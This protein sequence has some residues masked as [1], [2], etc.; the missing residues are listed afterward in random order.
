M[1]LNTAASVI[2]YVS[3][4]EL[5]SGKL[6]EEW[7]KLHEKVRDTFEMF[8]R[9]NKKN[10]EKVKR[11]Y[12]SVVSDALET[13]FCFRGLEGELT[14][15]EFRQGV[16]VVEVLDL[17]IGLENEIKD[18]YVEAADL[19]RCLLADVTREMQKVANARDNRISKLVAMLQSEKSAENK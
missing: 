5:E 2:K 11:A 4:L 10:E 8:S 6:Y 9:E 1:E 3:R 16:T 14:I 13:G 7:S 12:F 15:P 18:F 19:S 17:A